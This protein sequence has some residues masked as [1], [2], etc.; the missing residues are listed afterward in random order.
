LDLSNKFSLIK[1]QQINEHQFLHMEA[2]LLVNDVNNI[3]TS[4]EVRAGEVKTL[5]FEVKVE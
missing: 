5:K 4:S 1:F 3:N 2:D